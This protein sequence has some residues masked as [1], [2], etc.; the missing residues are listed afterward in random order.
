MG[1]VSGI[2]RAAGLTDD[3]SVE[4]EELVNIHSR[5]RTRNATL[6]AYYEGDVM[7]RDIGVKMLPDNA[8]VD[9]E[10]S[11]DWARKAVNA[12]ADLV[13]FDGFVFDGEED[14]GLQRVMRTGNFRSVFAR[15]RIG[16]LKNGCAFATVGSDGSK[17]YVRIHDANDGAAIMDETT[18]RLRSGFVLAR[19]DRTPWSPR[20]LVPVQ[21]NFF[22]PGKRV[23]ILRDGPGEWH[24]ERVE[25][26][27]DVMM[28]VPLVHAPTDTKPLGSTRITRQVRDLVDDVLR[29]RLAL[30]MSTAFYAVPMR[31]LLGL[32]DSA[33][34]KLTETKWGAYLNPLF[35]AT[36]DRNGR[37]AQP[38]QF[39]ANSP[40]PLIDLIQNDAKLF[41]GATGVPLNSLGVIHDNPSS[42]EAIAES[43]KDLTD[44]AQSLID[45]QLTP[46]LREVALLVMMVGSNVSSVDDL[47]DDQLSVLPHFKSPAMPSLSAATDAAMKIASVRP[48]FAE[49]SVFFEMTGFNQTTIDRA[50][51]EMRMITSRESL[52]TIL[53]GSLG[54]RE[55]AEVPTQVNGFQLGVGDADN[56]Q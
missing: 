5:M 15:N 30:V 32:S 42:A 18:D 24:A 34:K 2:A 28:M 36:M 31:A 51:H 4:L 11:C 22:M 14:E 1:D 13:A 23:T 37:T 41:A 3:E 46:A 12:L 29:V 19:S 40:Q 44:A 26:P 43:R 45:G 35:L 53:G 56:A 49:T 33:F 20:K 8:R 52:G 9:V 48:E 38:Y 17:P 50:V 21:A 55:R 25:T 16:I 47:S 10:L 54:T 6:E 39:P 27:E 7:A